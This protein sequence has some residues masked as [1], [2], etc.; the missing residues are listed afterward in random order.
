[1][2]RKI[3]LGW[4]SLAF[5]VLL[6]IGAVWF[7]RSDPIGIAMTIG[8]R[9][10][11]ETRPSECQNRASLTLENRSHLLDGTFAEIHT[12]KSIP[13][14][15]KANFSE[16]SEKHFEMADPGEKFQVGDVIV[17]EL[18]RRRLVFAGRSSDRFFIYFEQGGIAHW[19][20]LA[21]FNLNNH[22][23]LIWQGYVDSKDKSI[24]DLRNAL[25]REKP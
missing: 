4:G 6:A 14:D 22:G 5:L 24:D 9:P 11:E 1:M 2:S 10:P 13:A 19:W 12:T 18:P 17:E 21:V 3:L 20:A 8:D 15:V 7:F 25:Q 23:C 16:P